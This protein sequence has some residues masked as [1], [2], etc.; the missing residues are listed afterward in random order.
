MLMARKVVIFRG[1]GNDER[2]NELA[3]RLARY[4]YNEQLYLRDA[5]MAG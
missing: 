2:A 1:L 3:A 5:R 4:G